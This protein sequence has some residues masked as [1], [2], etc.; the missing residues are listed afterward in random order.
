MKEM[1]KAIYEAP[2]STVV[3]LSQETVVCGT[4]NGAKTTDYIHGS[5]DEN[6]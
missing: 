4:Q 3:E 1:V 6:D 5:L 2:S